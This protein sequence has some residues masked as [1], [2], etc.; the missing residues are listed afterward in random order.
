L[1][2]DESQVGNRL[3]PILNVFAIIIAIALAGLGAVLTSRGGLEVYGLALLILAG[4]LV[5]G[6]GS[7]GLVLLIRRRRRESRETQTKICHTISEAKTETRKIYEMAAVEGGDLFATHI[8][9]RDLEPKDDFAVKCLAN[10]TPKKDL[11]FYRV[12]VF[13]NEDQEE[14]W[15]MNLFQRIPDKVEKT[16][17]ILRRYPMYIPFFFHSVILRSNILLYERDRERISLLGL[18]KLRKFR[19]DEDEQEQS[20]ELAEAEESEYNFATVFHGDEVYRTLK[21]YFDFIR[22]RDAILRKISSPDEY[23]RLRKESRAM[24]AG[25]KA[26]ISAV[27]EF[28][29][30]D[31]HIVLVGL[32]GSVAKLER[33]LLPEAHKAENEHDIDLLIVSKDGNFK[34][35]KDKLEKRLSALTKRLDWVG[36]AESSYGWRTPEETSVHIELHVSGDDYYYRNPL[37]GISVFEYFLPLYRCDQRPLQSY[38]PIRHGPMSEEDRW[39]IVRSSKGG[40]ETFVEILSSQNAADADT[41]VDPRRVASFVIRNMVWSISGQYPAT[42]AIAMAYLENNWSGIFPTAELD[43]V[44]ELLSST[45]ETARLNRMTQLKLVR[46]LASDAIGYSNIKSK[47]FMS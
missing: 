34:G 1:Q 42:T 22:S 14:A 47:Q 28:A 35:I 8:F 9:P 26:A 39:T 23:R 41:G 6:S 4:V 19:E 2:L 46:A 43:L 44:R 32:F 29:E 40:F 36:Y 25:V 10:A 17:Y 38:L 45:L 31:E 11:K 16:F 33:G 5:L 27:G 18:D 30:G 20:I 3:E 37:L 15:I 12:L 13:E 7:W 21:R 24:P